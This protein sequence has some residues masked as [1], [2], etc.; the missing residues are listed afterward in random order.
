MVCVSSRGMSHGGNVGRSS[1][2]HLC[3]KLVA[4]SALCPRLEDAG[5]EGEC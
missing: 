4:S 3:P 2:L 1:E 5:S